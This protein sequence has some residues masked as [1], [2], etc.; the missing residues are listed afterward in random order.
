M[1]D[2][3][4][5]DAIK[6]RASCAVGQCTEPL[7]LADID[8]EKRRIDSRERSGLI[9]GKVDQSRYRVYTDVGRAGPFT[10]EQMREPPIAAAYVENPCLVR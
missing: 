8:Y 10:V 3:Q 1:Q 4:R 9:A 2:S 6:L 5:H 7:W